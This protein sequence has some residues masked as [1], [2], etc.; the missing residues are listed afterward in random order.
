MGGR[1]CGQAQGLAAIHLREE[2]DA[3]MSARPGP[4]GGYHASGIPTGFTNYRGAE[5]EGTVPGYSRSGRLSRELSH[6]ERNGVTGDR[7][8]P[9]VRGDTSSMLSAALGGVCRRDDKLHAFQSPNS[10]T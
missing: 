10:G 8:D 2:P 3:L 6:S 1:V 7:H 5:P 9:H 4:S